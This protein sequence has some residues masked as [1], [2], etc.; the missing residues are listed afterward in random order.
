VKPSEILLKILE[1]TVA[2][3]I[4][5]HLTYNSLYEQFQ[6]GFRPLHSTE[7]ALVKI[8]ND[9]LTILILLDLSAAFDTIS[10]TIL[11]DRFASLGLSDTPL[12]WFKSISLAVLSLYNLKISDPTLPPFLCCSPRLCPWTTFVHYLLLL[13]GHLFRKH[14]IQ[15]HCYADDTQLYLSTKPNISL[16]PTSLSNCLWE[17]RSWFSLNFFKLN[18]DKTELLLTGTKS[19]ISKLNNFSIIGALN[20]M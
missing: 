6:S 4:H 13:L 17:I 7:T 8:T 18:S 19:I 9:L 10:H 5:D 16:P 12:H 14:N 1:K 3:Q 2:S 20:K 15:F 11:N